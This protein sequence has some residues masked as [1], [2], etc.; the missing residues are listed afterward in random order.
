MCVIAQK[1]NDINIHSSN[2]ISKYWSPYG[3]RPNKKMLHYQYEIPIIK[4]I[5]PRDCLIF[6][7][8]ITIRIRRHLDIETVSIFVHDMAGPT[9]VTAIIFNS[10]MIALPQMIIFF[11]SIISHIYVYIGIIESIFTAIKCCSIRNYFSSL[12]SNGYLRQRGVL[13]Y[14]VSSPKEF[15]WRLI[16]SDANNIRPVSKI[17]FQICY[18]AF[19]ELEN[20]RNSFGELDKCCETPTRPHRQLNRF[21]WFLLSANT[22]SKT[23][24]I[25]GSEM[26]RYSSYNVSNNVCN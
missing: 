3:C 18:C 17:I 12:C 19:Q 14:L 13:L 2:I 9:C 4:I 22:S 15:P 11:H 10:S 23:R 16:S 21:W 24:N 1:P 20:S 5:G 7:K 26:K 6:I 25:L 8:G